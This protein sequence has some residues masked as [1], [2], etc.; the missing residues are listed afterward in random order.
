MTT[1]AGTNVIDFARHHAA[2]RN[3][4]YRFE[5]SSRRILPGAD[6]SDYLK[7]YYPYLDIAQVE[8]VFGNAVY[9]SRFYGGRGY[10]LEHSLTD[11]HIATLNGRGIG[12]SL[13]LTGHYFDEA[14]Y[15]ANGPFLERFHRPGNAIV[16]TN[17][18][19]ARRIRRDFPDYLLKASLIKHL[20]TVDKVEQALEL[21]DRAVIP[22]DMN[23]DDLFLAALPD[24][25]R[26]VLFANA[27]GAY[28][29]PARTCY[30]AISQRHWG[31]EKTPG[32]GCSTPWLPRQET[33]HTFFDVDKFARMGF[34][35]FKL[36]PRLN[37]NSEAVLR[38]LA[39]PKKGAGV[40]RPAAAPAATIHS[41]PKCGRT[42]LRTLLAHYLNRHFDLQVTV[43]LQT[44]FTLIP[45]DRPGLK[46]VEHYPFGHVARMPLVVA[47]HAAA[48]LR[49]G[50]DIL[51][52]RSIP[53][54]VVSDYFQHRKLGAFAGS[55]SEFIAWE[56]GS[57]SRYCDYLNGWAAQDAWL[58]M[59]VLTYEGLH[60]DTAGELTR[61]LCHLGVEVD[62]DQVA[63]AVAEASF[64][65]MQREEQGAGHA[66]M[67]DPNGDPEMFKVRKGK[68]GGY[69]DYLDQVEI[70]RLQTL[71][72]QRLSPEARAMFEHFGL[73]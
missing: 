22:M 64:A 57:L 62:P 4:A 52:L 10:N 20:T 27:N 15:R 49:R 3:P 38:M 37:P 65:A 70:E 63:E 61:L 12:V 33:G 16:C 2:F 47:S 1:P 54:V 72:A 67:P 13:T 42:W 73:G 35:H 40:A 68:V 43:N 32:A 11:R 18:T 46:G 6:P 5:V 48:S 50:G 51:L 28:A 36:V 71:V 56:E 55:L 8:A 66:G 7:V 44:L 34:S 9:P 53:D 45:N 25:E 19:L 26:I 17:D 59:H 69:R 31:K 21:Y 41:F 14:V 39:A 29:C 58:G 24:K 30:V 60:A 23:D